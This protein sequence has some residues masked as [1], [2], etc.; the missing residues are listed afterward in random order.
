MISTAQISGGLHV[1]ANDPATWG[2][3]SVQQYNIRSEGNAD[4]NNRDRNIELHAD[5]SHTGSASAFG[6]DQ[7]H[8][9]RMPY[10]VVNR[11]QRTA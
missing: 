1:R 5:H 3:F 8:E 6:S 10:Q 4:S 9:N 2:V 11:W 7:L